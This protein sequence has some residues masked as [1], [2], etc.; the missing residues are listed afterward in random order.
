LFYA[1]RQFTHWSTSLDGPNKEDYENFS[2][3]FLR[4]FPGY[5]L[6]HAMRI[7]AKP[8]T[9]V[10]N[11][12]SLVS[13]FKSKDEN[14]WKKASWMFDGEFRFLDGESNKTNKV[15]FASFPR[16]GNTFLRKYFE[17]L[18]G[19]QTGADNTLHNSVMLQLQGM[20][21]EDIVDDT[22]WIIK[23]HSPWIMPYAP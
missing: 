23:T 8:E 20:K 11:L 16:S 18:T 2:E 6:D 5:A 12:E 21:G 4:L 17:L 15:A 14:L 10:I 1:D 19:V 3:R 7:R 22:V 13:L 9:T